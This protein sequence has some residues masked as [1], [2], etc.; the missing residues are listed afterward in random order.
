MLIALS[1]PFNPNLHCPAYTDL[2]DPLF[3][4]LQ[5]YFS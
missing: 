4:T 3:F 5:T 1:I 2:F